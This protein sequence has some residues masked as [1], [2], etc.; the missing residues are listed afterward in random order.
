MIKHGC[1]T[2]GGVKFQYRN[3][4]SFYSSSF[5]IGD[6]ILSSEL[7]R[8]DLTYEEYLKLIEYSKSKDLKVGFSFF[9]FFF[10]KEDAIKCDF[11]KKLDFLKVPSA[12]CLNFDLI[13]YLLKFNKLLFI[14]TGGHNN[15]SIKQL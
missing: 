5:E 13:K 9:F 2:V 11:I 6:E 3:I 1:Q 7:K 14:S 12:E 15:F 10:R 4:A 8:S